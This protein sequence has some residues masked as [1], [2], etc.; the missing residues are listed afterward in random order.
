MGGQ[1]W[2][3][4]GTGVGHSPPGQGLDRAILA[5]GTASLGGQTAIHSNGS[6]TWQA[7]TAHCQLWAHVVQGLDMDRKNAQR[8]K[9]IYLA[10]AQGGQRGV[11]IWQWVGIAPHRVSWHR[12][13][14]PLLHCYESGI[15]VSDP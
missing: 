9:C 6:A 15:A 10:G 11:S 7:L 8:P 3:G 5:G 4:T 2:L 12:T 13:V 14:N 1:C